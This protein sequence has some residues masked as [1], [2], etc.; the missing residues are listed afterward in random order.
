MGWRLIR[1]R[2]LE[3]AEDEEEQHE[4]L[5]AEKCFP[6]FVTNVAAGDEK[7][8]PGRVAAVVI[9]IHLALKHLSYNSLPP[10]IRQQHIH[11]HIEEVISYLSLPQLFNIG[12]KL[13]RASG[14][15]P[16]SKMAAKQVAE[17]LISEHLVAVFSKTYCPYCKRAKE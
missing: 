1:R 6:L 9:H 12:A 8:T 15:T 7:Q 2:L 11:L 16:E 13:S 17:K 10:Y 4:K 3:A 14:S 5:S